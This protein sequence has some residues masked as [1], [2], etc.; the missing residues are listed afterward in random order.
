MSVPL[1]G[2]ITQLLKRWNEGD[3]AALDTVMI[4]LYDELR[5]LARNYLQ[6]ER[7]DH[8]LQPTALVNE[9]FLKLVKEQHVNWENRAH[10]LAVA[11]QIMRHILIDHARSRKSA[12]HGGEMTRLVFDETFD[13]PIEKDF[14]LIMLDDALVHLAKLNPMHSQIVEMRFFGGM[15]I[16]EIAI[17]TGVSS[18]TVDRNWLVAKTWLYQELAKK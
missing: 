16:D 1:P 2:E 9:S 6:N 7:K 11:A 12:K 10:F 8:T 5:S 4:M 18:R 3:K 15:S 13:K 17:V 14:D